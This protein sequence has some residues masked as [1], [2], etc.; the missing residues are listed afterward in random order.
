MKFHGRRPTGEIV[1]PNSPGRDPIVSRILWLR[2]LQFQN[3]RAFSRAI[4]IHGT[5][6]E[7]KIGTPASYGCIRM[8]SQDVIHLFDIVGVGA[9]VDVTMDSLPKTA[10]EARAEQIS[11]AATA[12]AASKPAPAASPASAQSPSKGPS[13][14]IVGALPPPHQG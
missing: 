1:K 5:A 11:A 8:R 12:N 13:S 14:P 3:A 10:T 4:Y 6:E 9:E 7:W 2:G